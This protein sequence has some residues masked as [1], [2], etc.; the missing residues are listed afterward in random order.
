MADRQTLDVYARKAQDY[1]DRFATGRP[2]ARLKDFIDRLP[3]GGHV[4]D[5]GCG[6]GRAAAAMMSRGLQ[7]DAWDASPE[8]AAIAS[9]RFGVTVRIAGFEDLGAAE[10]YD[11]I[12]ANFSLLHA[13]KS[14]MP[15]HLSRIAQALKPG[16]FLHL[17]L[18]SGS[19]EKRDALGRFYAYYEDD[20]ITGLLADV[21]ISVLTRATGAEAGLGGTIDPWIILK[22]RKND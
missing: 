16:G 6:P 21:G 9:D 18:K 5:L 3:E 1:A 19:G 15:G 2:D 4:L 17:G 13:P 8:M 22:A 7:V 10:V 14:Q 12:Y 20:E 11:G